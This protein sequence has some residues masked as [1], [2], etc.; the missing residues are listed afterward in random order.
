MVQSGK[1][2]S[3]GPSYRPRRGSSRFTA[4]KSPEQ[5]SIVVRATTR[6]A[7][8]VQRQ[9]K[10]SYWSTGRTRFVASRFC[11]GR[12]EEQARRRTA[13]LFS[14]SCH[15]TQSS[16]LGLLISYDHA[17]CNVRGQI[18]SIQRAPIGNGIARISHTFDGYVFCRHGHGPCVRKERCQWLEGSEATGIGSLPYPASPRIDAQESIKRTRS[19]E[20]R[21]MDLTLL[22]PSLFLLAL[23]GMGLMFAFVA[24]CDRV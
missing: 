22:L 13:R 17:P 19:I 8:K 7:F 20:G 6:V 23:I 10:G 5:F 14:Y 21:P 18:A 12:P 24:G 3:P 15:L 16:E 2:V 4:W 1:S 11:S 9:K